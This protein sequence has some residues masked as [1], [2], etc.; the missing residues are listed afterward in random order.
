MPAVY[1]ISGINS[2]TRR[3]SA[4]LLFSM[5]TTIDTFILLKLRFDLHV[6]A[7]W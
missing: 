7:P 6:A 5:S 1:L 4:S 2:F 3:L